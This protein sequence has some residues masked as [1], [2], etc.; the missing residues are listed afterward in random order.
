MKL[1]LSVVMIVLSY[2][3]YAEAA[4]K[5]FKCSLTEFSEVIDSSTSSTVELIQGSAVNIINGQRFS[6]EV[7]LLGNGFAKV[8]IKDYGNQILYTSVRLDLSDSR[9]PL[10][11]MTASSNIAESWSILGCEIVD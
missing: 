9:F 11:S 5:K 3:A 2:S 6:A 4:D 1:A 10:F 7:R 8:E